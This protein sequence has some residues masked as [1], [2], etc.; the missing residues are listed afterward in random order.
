MPLEVFC[1]EGCHG[2]GKSTIAAAL[3]R[4]GYVVLD[5]GF[6]D[7]ETHGLNPQSTT[8]SAAWVCRWFER[9]LRLNHPTETKLVFA[10]RSP[11]ST[12]IYADNGDTII[13]PLFAQCLCEAN[14]LGVRLTVVHV[15]VEREVLWGR[16]TERLTLEPARADYKENSSEWMDYVLGRYAAVLGKWDRKYVLQGGRPEAGVMEELQRIIEAHFAEHDDAAFV[17]QLPETPV[18]RLET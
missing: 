3:K 13:D 1:L 10:D 6:M 5:E 9:V 8:V 18:H 16:I 12:C 2:A 7:M 15:Q 11:F 14:A 4:Q 17:S